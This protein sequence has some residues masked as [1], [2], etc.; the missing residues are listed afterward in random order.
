MAEED[1]CLP[2]FSLMFLLATFS[3]TII[4]LE[5]QPLATVTT[6]LEY[7]VPKEGGEQIVLHNRKNYEIKEN[8]DLF[9]FGIFLV[10]SKF[11]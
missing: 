6:N 7:W 9:Y 3:W 11:I 4:H 8:C 1:W 2:I 10:N 5:T